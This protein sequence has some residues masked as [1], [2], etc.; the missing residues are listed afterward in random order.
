VLEYLW[1]S[2]LLGLLHDLYVADRQFLVH[3]PDQ[4]LTLS[5]LSLS[6]L[7]NLSFSRSTLSSAVLSFLSERMLSRALVYLTSAVATKAH[8]L[9]YFVASKMSSNFFFKAAGSDKG[10]FDSS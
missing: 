2:P 6:D 9:A 8:V 1:H 7:R 10:Q 5:A 4:R 3:R